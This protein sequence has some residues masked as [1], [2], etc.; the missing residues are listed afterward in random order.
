[1][2]LVSSFK[3]SELYPDNMKHEARNLKVL[4]RFT[5]AVGQHET[6]N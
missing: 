6:R 4:K 5:S 1:M 3:L 2:F